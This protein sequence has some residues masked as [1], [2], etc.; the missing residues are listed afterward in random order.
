MKFF[1]CRLS[2]EELRGDWAR[3]GWSRR[4]D[5]LAVILL[6]DTVSVQSASQWP[7][8]LLEKTVLESLVDD[9]LLV[10]VTVGGILNLL[11]SRLFAANY[12]TS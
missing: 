9:L 10:V 1:Q 5:L 4:I 3:L 6:V 2:L 12:R 11:G 8:V 7:F